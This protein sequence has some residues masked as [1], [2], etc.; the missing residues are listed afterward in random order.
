MSAFTILQQTGSFV[1]KN[2]VLVDLQYPY[3]KKKVYM[4]GSLMALAAQLRAAGHLVMI[5]DLNQDNRAGTEEYLMRDWADMIGI[6]VIGAPYIPAAIEF[7]CKYHNAWCHDGSR[8]VVLVGGQVIAKLEPS[9]FRNLFSGSNAL[10]VR[11]DKDL[12]AA[13]GSNLPG[14]DLPS[15]FEFPIS[16]IWQDMDSEMLKY[17]L[18]TEFALVLSQGC[19]YQCVYCG[20]AKKQKEQF[21]RLEVFKA[22]MFFLARKAK[23]F[24]LAKLEAYASSLDFF[25]N[26]EIVA[27]YLQALA[28]V[29]QETGMEF[30]VRCLSC[31]K[32][33]LRAYRKID[34]LGQLIR[35][36]GLWCV[37]FGVDGA[38]EAVWKSQHK[39]HNDLNEV[40][41]CLDI[42]QQMAIR[43]EVLTVTGFAQDTFSSLCKNVR[44]SVRYVLRWRNTVMRPYL[45]KPFIPGNDDWATDGRVQRMLDNFSLFYNLDFCA[46]AS[47]LTHPGRSHR[48]M[49]NAAYLAIIVLLRPFGRCCTSPL[50]PQGEKG[51]YG[52]LAKIVNRYMPF[53]R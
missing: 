15:A 5:F 38:D 4:N 49:S 50:L 51:W 45:A 33:F 10:Q 42:C 34:N 28:E 52:R 11:D 48:F 31:V 41:L 8:K 3:G 6:S 14:G 2:I 1:P 36:S 21:V 26:P 43:S 9:Q 37:G 19:S 30:R 32:S 46:L 53:D 22:D 39:T 13:V 7:A 23:Q 24:G 47:P 27:Q 40:V 25:Q 29:R 12:L 20:A 35:R 17:Y 18:S 44:N 16:R